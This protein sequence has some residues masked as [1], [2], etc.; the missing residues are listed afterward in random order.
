M[1]CISSTAAIGNLNDYGM[2]YCT[3]VDYFFR[4]VERS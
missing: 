3:D 2:Y 4:D 1:Y